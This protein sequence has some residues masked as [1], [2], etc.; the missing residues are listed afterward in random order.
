VRACA[1]SGGVG[2]F[3]GTAGEGETADDGDGEDE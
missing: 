2:A 1:A 3:A